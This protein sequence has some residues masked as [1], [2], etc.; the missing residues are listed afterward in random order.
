MRATK[1]LFV[2][3]VCLA[4]IFGSLTS[5]SRAQAATKF[6]VLH[7]FHGKDGQS[8]WA[9]VT[10]DA[11]GNL[12][13]T[14]AWGGDPT[15]ACGTVFELTPGANRKWTDRVLHAFKG[16]DG[17]YPF[18][19]LVFDSAGNLYGTTNAYGSPAGKRDSGVEQDGNVFELTPDGNGKWSET[20]LHAFDGADGQY[21]W[22][23]VI[24]DAAGNLYGTTAYG[25]SDKGTCYH[26]RCGVVF[27]LSPGTGGK[28]SDTTLLTFNLW[29]GAAPFNGLAR[30]AAGNLYGT[31]SI[32]SS[33][34][35]D[36][37]RL[38]LGAKG[39]WTERVLGHAAGPNAVILDAAGNLYATA[40]SGGNYLRCYSGCGTVFELVP[41]SKGKWTEKILHTFQNGKDGAQPV[42]GL[43]FDRAGNLYGMTAMGGA[44]ARY[45]TVFKLTPHTN[46]KWTN[47]VIHSFNGKDGSE[48][49][50]A[51]V[52]DPAG[53]LYGTTFL[54]GYFKGCGNP[55]GCGVV[56]KI[57]P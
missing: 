10:L 26:T 6:Q 51:L 4:A 47:T 50:G 14:T 37:F 5:A 21:P 54:G 2:A 42:G 55:D 19:T 38:T 27:K 45:G 11:A 22:A 35:G 48:P 24:L 3:V 15:C 46:G 25:G 28:W 32:G 1:P 17:S 30:D 12:Y 34:G 23:G 57:T 16:T 56:F 31:T 7:K 33:K 53:N 41:T 43:I 29:N 52:L 13:G 49:S 36:V 39:E 40:S 9:G 20:V 18:S 8:P 44:Y